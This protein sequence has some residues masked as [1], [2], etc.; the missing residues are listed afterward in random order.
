M[1]QPRLI[2]GVERIEEQLGSL[3]EPGRPLVLVPT[4]GDLH[5]GHLSLARLGA[6]LGPVLVS[7]FVNPAQFGPHEDFDAYPRDLERDLDLLGEIPGVA[8][9]FAPPAAE[10][11]PAGDSTFVEV[12]GVGEPLEGV[13]R[14][15]HLRGVATV[16]TKLF[17]LLRPDV[18]VF[19]QKD[20]QQCLVVQR[21][22]EDLRLGT[23]LVF[24]PTVRESDGLAMSSRNRY[25]DPRQREQAA[26]LH[27]ALSAGRELLAGGERR[28]D[29]VEGAMR[30]LL[31]ASDCEMDYAAMRGLPELAEPDLAGEQVLLAVAA[32]LGQARRIDNLSLR[33]DATGVAESPLDPNA[34]LSAVAAAWAASKE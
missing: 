27:R 12:D 30:E 28:R 21:L 25:L 14:P 16:V 11:Y 17:L 31:D 9:V 4:M 23:H 32:L 24:A 33:V 7:I 10:I 1:A 29:A 20:A 34:T 22:V 18:A 2:Q 6:E 8:A 26:E 13:Y 15:G 5:E 19:G 3:R